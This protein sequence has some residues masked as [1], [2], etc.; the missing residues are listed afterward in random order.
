MACLSLI[1]N[2]NQID[3]G[4]WSPDDIQA[5][6]VCEVTV[7]GTYNNGVMVRDGLNDDRMGPFQPH[8]Q[9]RTCGGTLSD[10][11]G[12]FGCITLSTPVFH[13]G[14]LNTV[15]QTLQ[16]VCP[17]CIA[18]HN[19][20]A[21]TCVQCEHPIPHRTKKLQTIIERY[22][23]EQRLKYNGQLGDLERKVS[24]KTAYQRLSRLSKEQCVE[25]GLPPESPPQWMITTVIPVA[26]PQVRPSITT[27]GR[28][29]ADDLT[30]KY[31][32]ILRA[33]QLVKHH[34]RAQHAAHVVAEVVG[35]LQWH[36]S[37]LIDSEIPTSA[38][39][40]S[41]VTG[42]VRKGLRQRLGGK[43]GRIRGNL[44]GKRVDF[45]ART[46]ITADPNLDIDQVGVPK[47]IALNMTI[48]ERVT[49]FNLDALIRRV[50][51]G[52]SDLQGARYLVK[53]NGERYDLSNASRRLAHTLVV[54]DIVERPLKDGDVVVMNR[55]PSLHKM[56]MMAHRVKV[57]DYSTFRLN[58]SVTSPYNAGT[59]SNLLPPPILSPSPRLTDE[60]R[61]KNRGR[62]R[63]HHHAV[64]HRGFDVI[65]HGLAP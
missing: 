31:S 29:M 18:T 1:R 17:N 37:T 34:L 3:F 53:Q 24:A 16:R 50:E 54:G 13:I 35:R 49:R 61:N 41:F 33:N 25:L 42:E 44:M 40:N 28:W 39:N 51:R 8:Q 48:P 38:H 20:N 55:Q 36:V 4:I 65:H 57:L 30:H 47:S 64:P 63:A 9:C 52:P 2:V 62:H 21:K 45:S 60:P 32:E 56:S 7:S 10:C 15:Y 46:V 5:T 19:P 58:L 11:P 23:D 26:P 59:S 22:T 6:A 12:H 27:K 43:A 14:F